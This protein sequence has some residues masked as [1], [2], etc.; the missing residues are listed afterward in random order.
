SLCFAA[1]RSIG[2]RG[3]IRVRP[4]RRFESNDADS[5]RRHGV[6]LLRAYPYLGKLRPAA[7]KV[8]RES[9]T[10][11]IEPPFEGDLP[12]RVQQG[13][14]CR[15]RRERECPRLDSLN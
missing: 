12:G 15:R 11:P 14:L 2:E 10:N 8:V 1:G 7:T 6:P 5:V 4:H 3:N 9:L 13:L